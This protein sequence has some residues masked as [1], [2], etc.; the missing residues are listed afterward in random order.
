MRT[1]LLVL[2]VLLVVSAEGCG[3]TKSNLIGGPCTYE[4]FAG[5]CTVT[6]LD[7][8]GKALFTFSGTIGATDVELRENRSNENPEI[9]AQIRCSIKFIKSGTCTPCLFSIG[10]CGKEAWEA[11][12]G[13]KK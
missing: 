10:E 1:L 6:R 2:S 5:M 13:Y 4:D 9:G 12:R 3:S 8:E 11:F 7:D